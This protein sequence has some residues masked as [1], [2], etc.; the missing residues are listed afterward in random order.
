MFIIELRY[1]ADLKAIDAA[2]AAH[3]RFV[4][5]QYA[6]GRFLVSGRKIPR[7]GGIIVATGGSREEI[8]A[9][10]RQDPFVTAGL[11]DVRVVEFRASQKARDI[12]ARI[13][14]E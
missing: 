12:Q 4:N 1:T 6:A 7:D 3:M 9:L 5:A 10:A 14:A 11:A 13:D 8:E 2:M